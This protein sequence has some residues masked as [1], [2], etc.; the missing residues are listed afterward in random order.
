MMIQKWPATWTVRQLACLSVAAFLATMS[1]CGG[2]DS[3]MVTAETSKYQAADD[4]G[5]GSAADSAGAVDSSATGVNGGLATGGETPPSQPPAIPSDQL[6]SHEVPDGTPEELLAFIEKMNKEITVIQQDGVMMSQQGRSP[7]EISS[8][9]QEKMGNVALAKL[10]AADKIISGEN[11]TSD[12]R[13]RGIEAK[14]GAMRLLTQLSGGTDEWPGKVRAFAQSLT[15]DKDPKIALQGRIILLGFRLGDLKRGEQNFGILMNEIKVLLAD[16]NRDRG[17]LD[18]TQTTAMEFQNAGRL[19]EAKEAFLAIAA[20]FKDH[21]DKSLAAGSENISNWLAIQELELNQKFEAVVKNEAGSD[22]ALVTAMKSILLDTP[23][24]GE[25][26]LDE[27]QQILGL[28]E[29]TGKYQLGLQIAQLMEQ[30]F[31]NSENEQLKQSS[32]EIS[33]GAKQRMGLVGKPLEVEGKNLDGSDFDFSKYKGKVVLL[34]FW[35]TWCGPCLEELPNIRSNYEAYKA[36]GFEVIG[37]NLDQDPQA[38]SGFLTSQQLP[39]ANIRGSEMAKKCGVDTIPF[40]VLLDQNG[41]VIDL[42][43]RE[44]VLGE[45]LNKLLGPPAAAPGVDQ[46]DL[47]APTTDKSS[48]NDRRRMGGSL[49]EFAAISPD[50][51]GDESDTLFFSR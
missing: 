11:T 40:V 10:K 39:W 25:V 21:P 46:P 27:A 16:E 9:L 5:S 4:T 42:H 13:R 12:N 29:Q 8:L 38:L 33:S 15:L 19:D 43:V 31:Q 32:A 1:G 22:E 34:D 7:A 2:S 28:L 49:L 18:I 23:N 20:A 50:G 36:K 41:V 48:S 6:D 45:K 14:L 24:P 3:D 17:V 35:A 26:V 47:N 44:N 30:G 37:V 51:G